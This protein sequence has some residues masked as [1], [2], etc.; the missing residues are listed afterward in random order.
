VARHRR[1]SGGA[2]GVTAALTSDEPEVLS[3]FDGLDDD[4]DNR[5]GN[6][7]KILPVAS[8][9]LLVGGG[10]VFKEPIVDNLNMF[11]DYLAGMG[12]SGFAL[13][14]AV[15]ARRRRRSL[16]VRWLAVLGFPP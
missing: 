7:V 15:R 13:Y 14:M 6:A 8:L 9:A 10:V 11:S 3:S 12:P 4:A 5:L 2:D 16:P 1:R